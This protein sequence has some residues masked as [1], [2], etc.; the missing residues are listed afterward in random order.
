[1]SAPQ[2]PAHG[3]LTS[4]PELEKG[5]GMTSRT[6]MCVRCGERP[7]TRDEQLYDGTDCSLCDECRAMRERIKSGVIESFRSGPSYDDSA[8]CAQW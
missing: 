3:V 8:D 4:D 7:A 6:K 5:D 1:M 2:P